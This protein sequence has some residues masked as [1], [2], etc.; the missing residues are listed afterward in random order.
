[1]LPLE[2]TYLAWIEFD[3]VLYGNFQQRLFENGLHVLRGD[4][5]LGSNFIR[6]N[7]ACPRALLEKALGI[8]QQTIH[9][10]H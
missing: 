6:L 8:I 3:E 1:M 10:S 2:A 9:E 5:F 7:F 4:Q